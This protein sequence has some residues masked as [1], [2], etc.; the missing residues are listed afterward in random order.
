MVQNGFLLYKNM[1]IAVFLTGEWRTFEKCMPYLLQNLVFYK[2]PVRVFCCIQ[3]SKHVDSEAWIRSSLGSA[4]GSLTWFD[5]SDTDWLSSLN[6]SKKRLQEIGDYWIQYLAHHS[7]SIIEYY[8]LWLAFPHMLMYEKDH[9]LVFD[10]VV[11]TR[12][13]VLL[14]K[15]IL[16]WLHWTPQEWDE[17]WLRLLGLDPKMDAIPIRDAMNSLVR[18]GPFKN[19]L[20]LLHDTDPVLFH[21]WSELRDYLLTGK[22]VLTYRKNIM[23]VVPRRFFLHADL[24]ITYGSD[25]MEIHSH[26]FDAESQ[27][28]THFYKGL[29]LSVFDSVTWS[30]GS[31]LYTYK[32]SDYWND[33][34]SLRNLQD[35]LFFLLRHF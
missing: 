6:A 17:Y 34:G 32:K 29:G 14:C 21:N 5:P 3:G 18:S 11:R 4:F 15:P 22:Y 26:W 7:G 13:D 1:W 25:R 10:F 8:Q 30:E 20:S 33:D 2:D 9:D 28:Q 23:Y 24:G 35:C 19:E 12:T 31:S 16:D 27:L